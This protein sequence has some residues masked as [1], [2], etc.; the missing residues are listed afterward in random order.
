VFNV[1]VV[2]VEGNVLAPV[3]EED[4]SSPPPPPPPPP[5]VPKNSGRERRSISC[6]RSKENHPAYTGITGEGEVEV[7]VDVG[8]LRTGVADEAPTGLLK[9]VKPIRSE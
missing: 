5:S 9:F 2:A 8:V 6:I 1:V 4:G 7:S 3:D